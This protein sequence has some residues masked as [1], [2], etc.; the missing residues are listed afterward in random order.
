MELEGAGISLSIDEAFRLRAT[1][2][3]V[4]VREV[5]RHLILGCIIQ[6]QAQRRHNDG[7]REVGDPGTF[8]GEPYFGFNFDRG[9]DFL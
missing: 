7:C 6:R 3:G 8:V 5:R 1:Y 4:N 9:S 2:M